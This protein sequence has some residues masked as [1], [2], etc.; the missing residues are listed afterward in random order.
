MNDQHIVNMA[1]QIASFFEA[2]P[3][4]SEAIDG[5]SGHLKKFWS[6][7][8]RVKLKEIAEQGLYKM[9]FCHLAFYLAT[10]YDF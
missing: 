4:Q 6:P 8:M 10:K 5:V 7:K 3:D 9:S 2:Y 1:N